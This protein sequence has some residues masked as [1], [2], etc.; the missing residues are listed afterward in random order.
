MNQPTSQSLQLQP[1]SSPSS[2]PSPENNTTTTTTNIINDDNTNTN[3]TT[4]SSSSSSNNTIVSAYPEKGLQAYK[5]VL[6]A[7]LLLLPAS[8]LLNSTGIFQAW[9]HANQQHQ[10][11]ESDIAW[12]YSIFAFLFFFGGFFVGGYMK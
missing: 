9:L 8:G 12:I 10:Y 7:W 3:T 11:P 5:Q 4:N 1:T 6:A 2:T